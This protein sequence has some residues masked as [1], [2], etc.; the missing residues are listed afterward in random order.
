MNLRSFKRKHEL[1][2]KN[3]DKSIEFH[4]V[5]DSI[6]IEKRDY[7]EVFDNA[8][9][10]EYGEPLDE[11]LEKNINAI[12]VNNI[13][14]NC[15]NYDQMLKP[16][17]KIRRSDNDYIQYKNSVLDKIATVYPSLEEACNKQKRKFDMVDILQG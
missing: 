5:I 8:I 16:M 3:K 13:R 15:S 6:T 10:F 7:R 9:Q 12:M 17:H 11:Y 4:K 14:H 2:K 1:A